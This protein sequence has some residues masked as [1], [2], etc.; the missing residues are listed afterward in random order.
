MVIE[1][2]TKLRLFVSASG[3]TFG[4]EHSHQFSWLF[5]DDRGEAVLSNA[6]SVAHCLP[7]IMNLGFY[8]AVEEAIGAVGE[9]EHF[10]IVLPK[11]HELESPLAGTPE[12]RQRRNYRRAS[13]NNRT[14]FVFEA[15][16]RAIDK[17]AAERGVT[18]EV[19]QADG[20]DEEELLRAA[21]K[22]SAAR[23]QSAWDLYEIGL[24]KF[25]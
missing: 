12:E 10:T 18:F 22:A 14:P 25:G 23:W 17:R 11:G 1:R 16:I 6:D 7:G 3:D 5:V 4:P 8:R 21:S 19:R 15:Q 24:G 9:G 13:K 20:F 2:H